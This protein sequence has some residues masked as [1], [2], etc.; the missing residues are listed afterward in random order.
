MLYG[1]QCLGVH[2]R[3]ADLEKMERRARSDPLLSQYYSS[4][5]SLLLYGTVKRIKSK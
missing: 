5:D 1:F 4:G 2:D 3:Q